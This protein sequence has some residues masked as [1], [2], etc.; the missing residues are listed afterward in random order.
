MSVWGE[1][2]REYR[3]LTNTSQ[4]RLYNEALGGYLMETI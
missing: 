2:T 3:A 4:I 1:S